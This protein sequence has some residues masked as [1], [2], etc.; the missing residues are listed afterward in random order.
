MFVIFHC[1]GVTTLA[2]CGTAPETDSTKKICA[3]KDPNAQ[4]LYPANQ[5]Y[6]NW[7]ISVEAGKRIKLECDDD[8]AIEE[9]EGCLYD[10]LEVSSGQNHKRGRH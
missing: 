1:I 4:K 10:Y 6:C 8:F 9:S 3:P 7:T 2:E 5:I